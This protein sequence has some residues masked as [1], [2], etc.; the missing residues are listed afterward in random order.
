MNIVFN[1]PFDIQI[2]E[3]LFCSNYFFKSRS[4]QT[5]HI[6]PK[7]SYILTY[8]S[9]VVVG[10]YMK[11]NKV[12]LIIPKSF[13]ALSPSLSTLLLGL[14][15]IQPNWYDYGR[16]DLIQAIYMNGQVDFSTDEGKRGYTC[17]KYG[18]SAFADWSNVDE[19]LAEESVA[20]KIFF[21]Y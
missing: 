17:P 16:K 8:V 6:F 14:K 12:L 4:T 13:Q 15:L 9:I 7:S 21:V 2:L 10:K 11:Y 5:F 1:S 19:I 3:N 18:G 20:K